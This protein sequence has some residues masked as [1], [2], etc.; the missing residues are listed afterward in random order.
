MS[1]AFPCS[2]CG[3]TAPLA[4]VVGPEA[5]ICNDCVVDAAN[6]ANRAFS[7]EL[8]RDLAPLSRSECAKRGIKH[9]SEDFAT[10]EFV[11]FPALPFRRQ[12][13]RVAAERVSL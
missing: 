4:L 9:S 5:N 2:F 10:S 7:S 11:E 13:L 12:L 8:E 6:E 3:D 1:L